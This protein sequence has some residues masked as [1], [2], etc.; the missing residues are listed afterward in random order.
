MQPFDF[1]ARTRVVFREGA[2]S[3]I[4]DLARSLGFERALIVADR[5]MMAAGFVDQ[6][7]SLF[8]RNHE[9]VLLQPHD[10]AGSG[11]RAI[12]ARLLAVSPRH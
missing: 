1:C 2:L 9:C 11:A 6:T 12:R 3:L 10:T 8:E 5:G 4:G 7:A